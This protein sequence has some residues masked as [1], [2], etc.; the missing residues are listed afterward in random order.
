MRAQMP[1]RFPQC[2]WRVGAQRGLGAGNLIPLAEIHSG[3]KQGCAASVV[4]TVR[5]GA[6][7]QTWAL[8]CP[9][10]CFHYKVVRT[11]INDYL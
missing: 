11:V 8:V 5:I 2:H 6:P 4:T 1:S 7:G 3:G 9:S 10:G